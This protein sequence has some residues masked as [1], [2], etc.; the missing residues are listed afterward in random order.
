MFD[1]AIP[2]E[3]GTDDTYPF[4]SLTRLAPTQSVVTRGR[5]QYVYSSLVALAPIQPITDRCRRG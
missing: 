4:E 1:P 3:P 5:P 2:V